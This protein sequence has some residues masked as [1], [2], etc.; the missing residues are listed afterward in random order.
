MRFDVNRLSTL[1][2]IPG[3]QSKKSLNEA[4]N[5]SKHEDPSVSDDV[6][7]YH[8]KGQLSEEKYEEGDHG[9]VEEDDDEILE[10]DE[11]DLVMELRRL[12][13]LQESKKRQAI[14]EAELKSI[15]DKEVKSV[16]EEMEDLNISGNWVYGKDKP[17]R[18]RRGYIATSFPGIGFK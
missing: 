3:N 2:G 4:S 7:Y 15:I 5:R 8:G 17:R 13:M 11:E 6:L 16:L 9:D 14:Q 10:I 18:S 12:R 1:A